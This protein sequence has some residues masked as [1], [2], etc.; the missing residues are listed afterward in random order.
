MINTVQI[1]DKLTNKDTE[2]WKKEKIRI[3]TG[4]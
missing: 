3:Y 1:Y 4:M 2:R